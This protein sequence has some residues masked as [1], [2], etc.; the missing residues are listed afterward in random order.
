MIHLEKSQVSNPCGSLG[1]DLLLLSFS[2]CVLIIMGAGADGFILSSPLQPQWNLR[3]GFLSVRR[4][5][6]LFRA[7]FDAIVQSDGESF[8]PN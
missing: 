2:E 3:S 6:I 8:Y 1:G 5:N 7:K 4:L